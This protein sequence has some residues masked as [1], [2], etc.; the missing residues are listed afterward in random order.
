MKKNSFVELFEY[1]TKWKSYSL[2]QGIGMQL[3]QVND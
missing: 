2:L 1:E 3:M